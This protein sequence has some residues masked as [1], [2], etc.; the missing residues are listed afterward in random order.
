MGHWLIMRGCP[1]TSR[2]RN[3]VS[4]VVVGH[5]GGESGRA[6]ERTAGP[7]SAPTSAR[8]CVSQ[9]LGVDTK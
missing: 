3:D 5:F 6:D 8:T 4:G 1:T 2:L 7:M 9:F